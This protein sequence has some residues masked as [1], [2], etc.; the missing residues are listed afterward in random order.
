[1]EKVSNA[2]VILHRMKHKNT[3]IASNN[4]D[5]FQANTEIADFDSCTGSSSPSNISRGKQNYS[6]YTGGAWI[7]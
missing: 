4:T 2:C 5:V 6:S 7:V 1:M 3:E